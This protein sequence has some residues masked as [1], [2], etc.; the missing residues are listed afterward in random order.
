M[1]ML[2]LHMQRECA[3]D[4]VVELGRIGIFQFID[5]NPTVSAFQRDFANEVRR[6]D[7][8]ERKIRYIT[9]EI[10][11]VGLPI[12]TADDNGPRETLTG[13]ERSIDDAEGDL[14]TLL[15]QLE[16]L[17]VE[18]NRNREHSELLALDSGYSGDSSGGLC[19]VAGVIPQDR[20]STL[21]RLVFR[22]TRGTAVLRNSP[23]Q[24]P[25]F[26]MTTGV[27]VRKSTF[28]LYFSAPRMLE[29]LRKMCEANAATIYPTAQTHDEL[30]EM[31]RSLAE[32]NETLHQTLLQTR[33]RRDAMLQS[34]AVHV[35]NWRRTVVV[36]KHVFSALNMCN[37]KA[38]TVCCEGWCPDNDVAAL[39]AALR[40]AER[41]TGA[42]VATVLET[43]HT[44]DTKPTYFRTNRFTST[45][46][47]IVD[48]YGTARYKEVNPGVFTVITFP[49]LFGV[50]YGD[51]GHGILLTIFGAFL[52]LME[53]SWEKQKLNEIVAMIYGG[54]YLLFLMG[55]F[56]TYVGILY[57]D[58]FGF[59]TEL[60]AS[61]YKWPELND[62]STGIMT[63]TYPNGQP[64]VKPDTIVAFG[65][66]SAWSETENKLE[67]YNSI[68]MKCAVII[69]IIQ[70]LLGVILS[71]FNHV[72][73]NDKLH[74]YFRFIPE[75]V[76]LS[77]TFGYMA[78]LIVIKWCT[79]WTN[80]NDAPSLLETMTNFFLAPGTVTTPL[81]AGQ[82]VVQVVL[83]L[84]AV[85]MVPLMLCVIP[86]VKKREN[87]AR[88]AN[89]RLNINADEEEVEEEHFDMSELVIHQII[90]TIEYVLGCVSNTA[91]YLRLWALSLAH[92]QLSDVFWNF[93]FMLT[94]DLDTGMGLVVFAGFA[95]WISA[96]IGVLLGMESLSAF[97][98]SLRLHWVE[99]QNKFYSGDGVPFLPFNLKDVLDSA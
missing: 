59:S 51:I 73:H 19:I 12:V 18:Y 13:V 57:N 22:A 5:L 81:Y 15:T 38:A 93:A 99:F 49:Y 47:G 3:H 50:M 58:M 88:H 52:I 65:I 71:L 53:K 95:V 41:S 20:I 8:M 14:R 25:F 70:M 98:H 97:L 56:A 11:K 89:P 84:V 96:T 91:S 60:F 94:V 75:I 86:I 54:R 40:R 4:T 43:L 17:A 36:E 82:T 45:F 1:V 79:A 29:R 76:F 69:G 61:G 34:Y 16:S 83:L 66:D 2:R 32:E 24:R 64:S 28:V 31:R 23:I 68:K 7:E 67:F 27:L 55:I 44:R 30:R 21:E 39:R 42:Q 92:A 6:C 10:T 77:A 72:Y 35:G 74:I 80:T 33:Q 9:D 85:T 87:D 63:P 46:Q 37:Y 26:N 78:L 62:R 90:H 48:A